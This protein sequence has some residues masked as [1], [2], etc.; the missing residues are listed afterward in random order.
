MK[1]ST[2]PAFWVTNMSPMNVTLAD[3][4][5][6]IKA[7]S[8]VNLLDKKHYAY[9]MEQLVKSKESGSLFKKRDKIAVRNLPP[10]RPEKPQ[11]PFAQSSFFPNRA[12]SIFEIDEVEYEELKV[13]D[14]DQKKQDEL[15]A[16]ENAD[17]AEIDN[18]RSVINPPV[19]KK[20]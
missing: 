9:T 8:T 6:N 10:P 14:E 11:T 1:T 13:S 20:V 17:L 18:Q 7:F 2:G 12:R 15:Y 3:L 5:L 16:Q 4:A 19:N